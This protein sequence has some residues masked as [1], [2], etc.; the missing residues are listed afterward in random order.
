[1]DIQIHNSKGLR[2]HIDHKLRQKFVT[3][4]GNS[5]NSQAINENPNR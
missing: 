4:V 2:L 3:K 5:T 1:M